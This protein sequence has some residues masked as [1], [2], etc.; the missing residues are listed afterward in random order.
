LPFVAVA[1]LAVVLGLVIAVASAARGSPVS[2][3]QPPASLA[4]IASTPP[5]AAATVAPSAFSK[6]SPRPTAPAATPRPTPSGPAARIN[7]KV[8]PG[9]TLIRIA[10]LYHVTV[11]QIVQ[12][13][14]IPDPHLIYSGQVL[15]IPQPI[16]ASP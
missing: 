6:P 9:D 15:V 10:A 4:A 3:P 12:A 13:N 11:A 2:S 7:Y 14:R 16:Q 5:V 8:Q 1:G